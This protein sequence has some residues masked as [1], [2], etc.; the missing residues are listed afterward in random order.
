PAAADGR[1]TT[2]FTAAGVR[3]TRTRACSQPLRDAGTR[4]ARISP[5]R[6][7]LRPIRAGRDG[8]RPVRAALDRRPLMRWW[9]G[10]G[11]RP[12]TA[13]V[14][15]SLPGSRSE[16]CR[17]RGD[18]DVDLIRCE[19]DHGAP[20]G[21]RTTSWLLPEWSGEFVVQFTVLDEV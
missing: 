17:A 8:L 16:L 18:Q 5:R 12:T 4:R 13:V 19:F 1:S 6:G 9:A 10:L 15:W 20:H 11:D 21:F 14:R 7:G 3:V 2:P